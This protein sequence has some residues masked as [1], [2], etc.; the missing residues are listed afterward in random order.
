MKQEGFKKLKGIYHL[1]IGEGEEALVTLLEGKTKERYIETRGNAFTKYFP[2]YESMDLS[3]YSRKG[4]LPVLMSRGCIHKCRFCLERLIYPD[5]HIKKAGLVFEEILYHYKNNGVRW[6]TFYDSIFN[7]NLMELDRLLDLILR[8]RLKIM[9]DAQ[10]A[11]RKDMGA[12]LLKKMKRAGCI[13]LFIGL[14]SGS[15]SL[16]K[17]M[18]KHF[19]SEEAALFFQKLRQAGLQFEVSLIAHY[20][21]ETEKQLS[22]T[23]SFL[24]DNKK[25]IPKVAQISLFRN[26]PGTSVT[27]PEGYNEA[28]GLEKINRMLDFL[29]EQGIPYTKSYVNNLI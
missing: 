24:R 4:S 3:L 27:V 7:G 21:G 26:Y 25:F 6:F 9:W 29:K 11:V 1:I 10:I 13:N 20:P 22:E 18:N 8:E 16:L 17:K 2:K 12:A 15:D 23:L 5:Y 19:T 14:E 28:V